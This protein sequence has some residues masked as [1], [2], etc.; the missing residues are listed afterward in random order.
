MNVVIST[1]IILDSF[2]VGDA[3]R[4]S[5]T[6]LVDFKILLFIFDNLKGGQDSVT[7]TISDFLSHQRVSDRY[8][9]MMV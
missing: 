2:L 1:V 4:F 3:Q 7:V 5:E 9:M 6:S 8:H